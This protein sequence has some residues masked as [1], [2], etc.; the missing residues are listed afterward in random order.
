ML[1]PSSIFNGFLPS[2]SFISKVLKPVLSSLTFIPTLSNIS[3]NCAPLIASL[4]VLDIS[5][6]ANPLILPMAFSFSPLANSIV[7]MSFISLLIPICILPSSFT[8][9][10]IDDEV[11]FFSKS[12]LPLSEYLALGSITDDVSSKIF[13]DNLAPP[14]I[15]TVSPIGFITLP[16][17]PWILDLF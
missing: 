12:S 4:E 9:V 15:L 6:L 10:A 11:K 13:S 8:L 3:F 2:I 17:L 7:L 5:P 1:S 14:I 16:L